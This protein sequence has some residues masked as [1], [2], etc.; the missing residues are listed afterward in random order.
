MGSH[1]EN[2]IFI[3]VP[4]MECPL[5]LGL[6]WLK[7]W[8]WKEGILGFPRREPAPGNG[9]HKQ[10]GEPSKEAAAASNGKPPADRLHN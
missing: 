5:V 10:G 9:S 8:N 6:T 7:C 1:N 3:V 2:L 4:E